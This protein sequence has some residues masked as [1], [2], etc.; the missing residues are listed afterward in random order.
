VAAVAYPAHY[1]PAQALK[2]GPT[3]SRGKTGKWIPD[4]LLKIRQAQMAKAASDSAAPTTV[5]DAQP[6]QTPKAKR[7]SITTSLVRAASMLNIHD[8]GLIQ[9]LM[10]D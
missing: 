8:N 6:A 10:E 3:D 9:A 2:P 4:A 1:E 7:A 5:A